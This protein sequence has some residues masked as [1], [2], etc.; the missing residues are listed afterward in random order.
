MKP[1]VQSPRNKNISEQNTSVNK[2]LTF[3]TLRC[4]QIK[5]LTT[6]YGHGL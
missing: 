3:I 2:Y 4:K 6:E 1:K 5:Q